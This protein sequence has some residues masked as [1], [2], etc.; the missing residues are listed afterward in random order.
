[1]TEAPISLTTPVTILGLAKRPD[2]TR[3]GRAVLSL[4]ASIN[5]TTYEVN[6]VS[7][8]GQGIEQVLS[9]LANAGYLTK[10]GKE[11]TLEVPT[12]TLGKAKNNVIW[13]HV[14]DYEKLKGTT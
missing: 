6:L 10:N 14:E 9:Y 4:N 2:V 5:G 8:P 11:F 1:M 13:V 7:K 12:W 3:D